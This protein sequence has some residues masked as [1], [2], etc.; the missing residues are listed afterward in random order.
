MKLCVL[1]EGRGFIFDV[2]TT[3]LFTGVGLF[4]ASRTNRTSAESAEVKAKQPPTSRLIIGEKNEVQ[5]DKLR[6]LLLISDY[7]AYVQ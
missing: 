1:G 7:K 3:V 5:R 4:R 2:I 6:Y